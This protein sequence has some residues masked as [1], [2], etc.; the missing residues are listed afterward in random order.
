MQELATQHV[1]S[2]QILQGPM[3]IKP[4]GQFYK[5]LTVLWINEF[6]KKESQFRECL[7]QLEPTLMETI[8]ASPQ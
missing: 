2:F 8:Q 1:T 5:I 3:H 6:S 4:L 7:Q